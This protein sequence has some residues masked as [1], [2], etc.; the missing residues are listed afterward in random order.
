MWI[1]LAVLLISAGLFVLSLLN[2]NYVLRRYHGKERR[3]PR[4][5]AAVLEVNSLDKAADIVEAK[6]EFYKSQSRRI[7][8]G[9]D[10]ARLEVPEELQKRK[11]ALKQVR[12]INEK[13]LIS[14]WD[15]IELAMVILQFIGSFLLLLDVPKTGTVATTVGLG[16]FFCWV[17]LIQ[18]LRYTPKYYSHFRAILHSIPSVIKIVIGLISMFVGYAFF[19][20]AV[21]W[22]S[23]RFESVN[24]TMLTLFSLMNGDGIFQLFEEL[25]ELNILMGQLY[26]YSFIFMFV[27]VGQNLFLGVVHKVFAIDSKRIKLNKILAEEVA[28]KTNQELYKKK[29]KEVI[30]ELAKLK[31]LMDQFDGNYD[32]TDEMKEEIAFAYET[33]KKLLMKKLD[34]AAQ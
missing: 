6:N 14:I 4:N 22:Q 18:H 2:V 5:V 9:F 29:K 25:T 33:L 34:D 3:I 10:K 8:A 27:C 21:F 24:R 16:C 26:L 15:F 28:H 12:E 31:R 17:N 20:T 13:P 23:H 19:G 7:D 11:A 1:H 30:E 32:T